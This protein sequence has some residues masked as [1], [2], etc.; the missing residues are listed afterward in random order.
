MDYQNSDNKK[1][2]NDGGEEGE[3]KETMTWYEEREL[4]LDSESEFVNQKMHQTN[5][6]CMW[7]KAI[8]IKDLKMIIR[9][10]PLIFNCLLNFSS[11]CKKWN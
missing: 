5:V 7:L 8:T 4:P 6:S 3:R 10:N 9:M 11:G 2:R 1:W